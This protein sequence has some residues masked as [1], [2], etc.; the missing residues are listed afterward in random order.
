MNTVIELKD[1]DY[2]KILTL[3]DIYNSYLSVLNYLLTEAN[4]P[5]DNPFIDKKFQEAIQYRIELDQLERDLALKYNPDQHW[6]DY[7]YNFG[8]GTVEYIND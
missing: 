6:R 5:E 3:F 8:D 4:L 1:G 2:R 7:N